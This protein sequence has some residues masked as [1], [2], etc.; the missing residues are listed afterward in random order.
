MVRFQCKHIPRSSIFDLTVPESDYGPLQSL[1]SV[2]H[3]GVLGKHATPDSS[4]LSQYPLA[5]DL[6]CA[7]LPYTSALLLSEEKS[8]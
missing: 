3:D 2:Q 4:G 6:P 1:T 5:A 7:R 8:G